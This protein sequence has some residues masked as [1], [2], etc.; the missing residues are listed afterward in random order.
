MTQIYSKLVNKIVIFLILAILVILGVMAD[1]RSVKRDIEQM[2][3]INEQT[4]Q[5]N[6]LQKSVILLTEDYL[7]RIRD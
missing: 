3:I 7:E 5:I 4:E 2:D 1:T 6:S